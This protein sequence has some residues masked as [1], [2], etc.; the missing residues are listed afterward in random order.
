MCKKGSNQILMI[1]RH[2]S[3][4]YGN[5]ECILYSSW[6]LKLN[7]TVLNSV[8]SLKCLSSPGKHFLQTTC[9]PNGHEDA[10]VSHLPFTPKDDAKAL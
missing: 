3:V 6:I 4:L 7:Y 5:A 10:L 8:Q 2:R 1:F 9:R